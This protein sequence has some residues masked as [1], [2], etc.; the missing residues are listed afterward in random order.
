MLSS[1]SDTPGIEKPKVLGE[2]VT[3]KLRVLIITGKLAAGTHLVESQ[4]SESFDVSRGPIR[5]AL[6][7]LTA[8]GLVESRK[9]GS[10]V[11]G[12]STQD[13]QELYSVR[14]AVET[15]A[16]EIS[17]SRPDSDWT[18]LDPK[19]AAMRFA[20]T[21]K[22]YETFAAADMDFHR[23]LFTMAQNSRLE[24]IWQ[25]YEPTFSV[26]LLITNAEDED[27]TPSLDSHVAIM[28]AGLDRQDEHAKALLRRHLKGSQ[29]RLLQS[30]SRMTCR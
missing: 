15:K 2:Q 4:L 1:L 14:E 8:E 17:I 5:H 12:L 24:Q 28:K 27:L 21:K 7:L 6:G 26:L 19:I 9:R 22:D 20:S 30:F 23:G 29:E 3:E 13:I 18:V 10:F 16:L 11:R 25:R